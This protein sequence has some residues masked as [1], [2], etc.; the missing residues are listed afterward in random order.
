MDK[1]KKKAKIK[2]IKLPLAR[3]TKKE[4]DY[5][6]VLLEDTNHNFK[7]F[8][9]VLDDVRRKGNATFEQVVLNSEKLERLRLEVGYI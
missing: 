4:K 3:M 5:V 8:W 6:A 1:P 7:A 9:E 2:K